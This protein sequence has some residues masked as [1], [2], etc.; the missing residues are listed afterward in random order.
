MAK[1][2]STIITML[3]ATKH[4]SATLRGPD[5]VF[6]NAPKGSLIIDCSTIDPVATRALHSEAHAA[7]HRLIDAPVSGGVTGAEKGTLT[8][9]VG[10]EKKDFD[11]AQVCIYDVRLQCRLNLYSD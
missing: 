10:G 2:S 4:V 8:F 11:D 9:M 3:P 5:G 1:Q 6:A 7:G